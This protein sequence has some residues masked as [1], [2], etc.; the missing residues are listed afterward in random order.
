M[1]SGLLLKYKDVIKFL[2][3]TSGYG[4]N[5]TLKNAISIADAKLE[6]LHN[7]NQQPSWLFER[8]AQHDNKSTL[9]IL[10]HLKK[11]RR[12][13]QFTDPNLAR[14]RGGYLLGDWV[15]RLER[16]KNGTE[17]RKM[18]MYSAHD[19]TLL[20]L[21]GTM[22][23]LDGEMVP[24]ASAL[25]M[26]VSEDTDGQLYIEMY[27]RKTDYGS[28]VKQ[29]SEFKLK[30]FKFECGEK[31]HID[32]FIDEMKPKAVFSKKDMYQWIVADT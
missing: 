32:D 9:E 20:A 25:I 3:K 19:G 16:L 17:T 2:G 5:I 24:Y 14:L 26:E 22:G 10:L 30:R 27:Y 12:L 28:L 18:V 1:D 15:K 11:I 31:C 7:Y 4:S 6:L 8:W 21:M 23:I 29:K 13:A